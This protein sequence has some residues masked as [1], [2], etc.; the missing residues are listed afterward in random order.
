MINA[1]FTFDAQYQDRGG[2]AGGATYTRLNYKGGIATLDQAAEFLSGRLNFTP[3]LLP[4]RLTLRLDGHQINN[5]DTTNESDEVQVMAPQMS[6]LNHRKTFYL[7]LGYAFS[8]YA[9]SSIGNGALTVQQWTPTL[10]L[11]FNHQADWLQLRLYDVRASNVGRA[12]RGHTDALEIKLTHYFSARSAW[13]P[14]SVTIGGLVGDRMYTLDPDTHIV[15][16]LADEQRGGAFLTAQWQLSRRFELTASGGSDRYQARD[17][18]RG[19]EYGYTGTYGYLGLT[20]H[21]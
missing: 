5:N 18:V 4:G 20:A 21:W 15:Y 1:G 17:S 13:L 6:F 7:D 19:G 16:N 2:L 8:S 14:R 3:D 12:L 11:G 9:K 10:G